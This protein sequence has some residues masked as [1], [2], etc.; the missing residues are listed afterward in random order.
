MNAYASMIAR[1]SPHAQ[2][3]RSPPPWSATTIGRRSR[4]P[5]GIEML[6]SFFPSS[7][8]SICHGTPVSGARAEAEVVVV[9][10]SV[11][12][13]NASAEGAGEGEGR[14]PPIAIAA[15]ALHFVIGGIIVGTPDR[16]TP[17]A[18]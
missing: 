15:S 11:A 14:Q 17:H 8:T 18:E 16:V 2:P 1:H 7:S 13:V 9:A 6:P 10:V 12:V 4:A 3:G 5:S